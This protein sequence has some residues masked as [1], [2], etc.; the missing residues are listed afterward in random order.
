MKTVIETCLLSTVVQEKS[1]KFEM[2]YRVCKMA[3]LTYCSLFVS[4]LVSVPFMESL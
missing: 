1:K 4:D 2:I 3:T